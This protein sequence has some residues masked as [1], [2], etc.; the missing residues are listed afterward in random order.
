VEWSRANCPRRQHPSRRGQQQLR[1]RPA[2]RRRLRPQTGR[3]RCRVHELGGGEFSGEDSYGD[4]HFTTP[5]GHPGVTFVASSGDNGSPAGWPAVSTRIVGVGGTSVYLD[6]SGNYQA[7]SPTNLLVA[8]S[9]GDYARN[10]GMTPPSCSPQ[11]PRLPRPAFEDYQ[12]KGDAD[13]DS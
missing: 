1:R 9:C 11:R 12:S 10:T 4:S 5:V 13:A 3:G 6:A 2:G 7:A 8:S